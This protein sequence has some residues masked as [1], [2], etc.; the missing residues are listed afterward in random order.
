MWH[1]RVRPHGAC[2]P[3]R[4]ELSV[5]DCP[6]SSFSACGPDSSLS[7]RPSF[8]P[9]VLAPSSACPASLAPVSGTCQPRVCRQWGQFSPVRRLVSGATSTV[10]R[11]SLP[12][13]HLREQPEQASQWGPRI[14]LP[15]TTHPL[16]GH[17]SKAPQE[18]LALG[19]ASTAPIPCV[20]HGVLS[21]RQGAACPPLS[22]FAFIT[23]A[24]TLFPNKGCGPRPWGLR[25]Q[26]ASGEWC[27]AQQQP[28]CPP[29]P[30][31]LH[32]PVFLQHGTP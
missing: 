27:Y 30:F 24:E 5:G 18:D 29:P 19:P 31:S 25:P 10:E 1:G 17:R 3:A 23:S 14:S 28:V 12:H 11:R 8:C 2:V 9:L 16:G 26:Q 4:P 32:D 15:W 22:L 13:C 6:P 21:C 7:E 20:T